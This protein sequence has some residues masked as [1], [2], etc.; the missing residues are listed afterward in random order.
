VRLKIECDKEH[1]RQ[2]LHYSFDM[3]K[4]TAAEAHRFISKTYFETALSVKTCEY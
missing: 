4:K 2:L 3:K 1:F